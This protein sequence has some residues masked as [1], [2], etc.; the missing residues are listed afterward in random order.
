MASA[1]RVTLYH[2]D[3]RQWP[4]GE[5]DLITASPPYIPPGMGV[6]PQHAQKAA[7]RFELHGDIFDYCQAAARSLAST[8]VLCFCHAAEDTR[9]PR[10]IAQAKLVLVHRQLVY[11]RATLPPRIA[12]YTCAWQGAGQEL[13]PFIIRDRAGRWTAEYL[14]MREAMGASAAFLQQARQTLNPSGLP[15]GDDRSSPTP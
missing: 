6:Q 2:Q 12:L 11:F 10:A 3:L 9:P 14:A 15:A 5:F 13:P 1:A 7:A 4:G 8:G